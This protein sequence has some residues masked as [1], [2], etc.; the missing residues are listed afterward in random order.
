MQFQCDVTKG[1]D[2]VSFTFC[3]RWARQ[4]RS[5]VPEMLRVTIT[6]GH[7]SGERRAMVT[8]SALNLRTL[9]I[10]FS[11]MT[12]LAKREVARA[13]RSPQQWPEPHLTIYY[14]QTTDRLMVTS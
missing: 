5:F 13:C 7:G 4:R 9:E 14:A 1:Y 6:R 8:D 12:Q 3:K 10:F 11:V 2:D